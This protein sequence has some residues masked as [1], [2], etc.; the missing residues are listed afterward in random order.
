MCPTTLLAHQQWDLFGFGTGERGGRG[1]EGEREFGGLADWRIAEC[2]NEE[3]ERRR[4]LEAEM[5]TRLIEF[6]QVLSRRGH[7][8]VLGGG[9]GEGGEKKRFGGRDVCPAY[10]VYPPTIP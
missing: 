8:S 5:Y 7:V 1:R 2:R 3:G 4:G 10:R 6:I 9:E